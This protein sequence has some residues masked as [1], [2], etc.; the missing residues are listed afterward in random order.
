MLD[1][2]TAQ[3]GYFEQSWVVPRPS[4]SGIF[5][6]L[7]PRPEMAAGDMT[8]G[9]GPTCAF[10]AGDHFANGSAEI[11][12]TVLKCVLE[13]EPFWSYEH[14]RPCTGWQALKAG[15]GAEQAVPRDFIEGGKYQGGDVIPRPDQTYG[16]YDLTTLIRS[17]SPGISRGLYRQGWGLYRHP[18]RPG[19]MEADLSRG[20]CRHN[21]IRIY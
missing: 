6:H 2:R 14:D 21:S 1:G 12:I 8:A 16:L 3:N 9:N 13:R 18:E 11:V 15:K 7:L 20:L 10:R 4:E 5:S 19:P 17:H